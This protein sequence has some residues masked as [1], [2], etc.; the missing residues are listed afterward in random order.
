MEKRAIILLFITCITGC[1]T[2]EY[3]PP[4]SQP[5]YF[6]YEYIN[7]AWG[8]QNNG[9]IIDAG[10]NVRSWNRPEDWRRPDSTGYISESD[11]LY[12]ISET[13]SVIEVVGSNELKKHVALIEGAKDGF[14]TEP[15]NIGN[16]AGSASLYG[17]WYDPGVDAYLKVF[18]GLSGDYSSENTSSEAKKLVAWLKEFGVF[19][20]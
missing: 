18:L 6:E 8:Y 16:D 2:I 12:N 19:W 5:V 13:D 4:E 9:W 20:L 15:E 17:Y 7:F 1:E 14:I 3:N 11:L 10:G